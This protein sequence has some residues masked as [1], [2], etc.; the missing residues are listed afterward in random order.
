MY[1][2][3]GKANSNFTEKMLRISTKI[4][5]KENNEKTCPTKYMKNYRN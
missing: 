3:E 1:L 5:K 4:L 2:T